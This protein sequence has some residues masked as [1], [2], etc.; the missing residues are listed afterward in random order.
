MRYRARAVFIHCK[1]VSG[2][3]QEVL[4][5]IDITIMCSCKQAVASAGV[6]RDWP[7][8]LRVTPCG[9]A[10]VEA[11]TPTAAWEL[12]FRALQAPSG[13]LRRGTAVAAAL[14]AQKHNSLGKG[15]GGS[16]ACRRFSGARE[17]GLALPRVLALLCA[18]PHAARCT[19]FAAWPGAPPAAEPLVW[20]L[21][22]LFSRVC[23]L[24][25]RARCFTAAISAKPKKLLP[26]CKN[27]GLEPRHNFCAMLCQ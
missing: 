2:W 21:C 23:F 20:S 9:C 16:G 1:S 17:F 19:R 6:V 3:A 15:G 13:L 12:L 8:C 4:H 11:A 26:T 18:L 24:R 5:S 25:A 14:G 7:F 27:V 10:P 22:N